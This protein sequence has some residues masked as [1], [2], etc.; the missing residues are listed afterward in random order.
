M[1]SG[2]T[3][4]AGALIR[5]AA[6]VFRLLHVGTRIVAASLQ[7]FRQIERRLPRIPRPLRYL[8]FRVKCVQFQVV[9]GLVF[10]D[11]AVYGLLCSDSCTEIGALSLCL[12]PV[13]SSE[14]EIRPADIR[15][16]NRRSQL[17]R[18]VLAL[19]PATTKRT[20]TTHNMRGLTRSLR[21]RPRTLIETSH[22]ADKRMTAFGNQTSKKGDAGQHRISL[23]RSLVQRGSG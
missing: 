16:I 23:R 7:R 22:V 8:K 15:L 6:L 5:D 20:T 19:S 9:G 14:A 1:Q 21:I 3:A 13:Q 17:P 11:G 12:P 4:I 18:L 10:H 2:G